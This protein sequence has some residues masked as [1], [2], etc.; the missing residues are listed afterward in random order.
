MNL[1]SKYSR[2][3]DYLPVKSEIHLRWYV[4]FLE[5]RKNRTLPEGTSSE[6]HHI[7]PRDFLPEDWS[8][9]RK[10]KDNIIKLTPREYIIAHMILE[11]ITESPSM[12]YAYNMMVN[13]RNG[14]GEVI[15][16]TIKEA[17]NLRE[18]Q[19]S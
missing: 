12:T 11:K 19:D 9:S 15:K 14:R 2:H 1:L 13:T 6:V 10:D 17:A 3:S 7:V 16:L 4:H 8:P 5:S 18:V